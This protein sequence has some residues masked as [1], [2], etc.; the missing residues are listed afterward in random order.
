MGEKLDNVEVIFVSK[1]GRQIIV[2]GNIN[3][4]F[5]NGKTI[6]TRAIFRNVTKRKKIERALSESE[7]RQRAILENAA[8]GIITINENAVVESFNP[9]AEKIF[10]YRAEEVVGRNVNILQ[11]EPYHSLHNGYIRN[12]LTTSKARVIGIGREVSGRRKDGTIF[13][14]YL[15]VS[16]VCLE[17]RRIFTGIVRDITKRKQA[18][19]ALQHAKEEAEAA[20]RA[21]SEFLASMSHE[22]R[23][24]MNAII[25]MAE[26]LW[27]TPLTL[28]QQLRR[29]ESGR[30]K[31]RRTK[32]RLLL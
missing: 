24:P 9:A 13:P 10:G 19:E 4:R 15:A 12:Y 27:E 31:T 22:I 21:K 26:L 32:H 11:P 14:L 28:E 1:D 25:G 16:E 2:E 3:C 20:N 30:R 29:S 7:A 6:S 5:K 8:D 17:N 18:E 23:T